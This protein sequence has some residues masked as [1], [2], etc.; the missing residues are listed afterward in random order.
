MGVFI[1]TAVGAAI[2]AALGLWSARVSQRES[3]PPGQATPL[4]PP[5]PTPPHEDRNQVKDVEGIGLARSGKGLS[6]SR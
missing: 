6:Q 2:I 5:V 3:R 4:T 1:V